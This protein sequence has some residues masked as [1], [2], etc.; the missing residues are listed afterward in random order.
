[1]GCISDKRSCSSFDAEGRRI[2]DQKKTRPNGWLR[3]QSIEKPL[4]AHI[5]VPFVSIDSTQPNSRFKQRYEDATTVKKMNSCANSPPKSD[6][7]RIIFTE[8]RSGA[9]VASVAFRCFRI[10]RQQGLVPRRKNPLRTPFFS[11]FAQ[12]THTHRQYAQ[13]V[14]IYN[15]LFTVF[16]GIGC[17]IYLVR[18]PGYFMLGTLGTKSIIEKPILD[19]QPP[20]A[21]G[22]QMSERIF[23]THRRHP[24][25]NPSSSPSCFSSLFCLVHIDRAE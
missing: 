18:S 22:C 1:M 6:A 4:S 25:I 19:A 15:P 3:V 17:A 5:F 23:S 14:I 8:S 20:L 12:E 2:F 16:T 9:S 11:S 10:V 13:V 7:A 21:T 24:I